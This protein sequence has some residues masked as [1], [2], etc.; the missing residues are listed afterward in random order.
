MP[1]QKSPS[2]SKRITPDKLPALYQGFSESAAKAQRGYLRAQSSLLWMLVATAIV[3]AVGKLAPPLLEASWAARIDRATAVAA[4]TLFSLGLVLTQ[5]HR[6]RGAPESWYD[7]RALAES[8]KS[9]AWKFLMRAEPYVDADSEKVF[10]SDLLKIMTDARQKAKPTG[11]TADQ[12]TSEMRAVRALPIAERVAI[13]RNDRILDQSVWYTK[14][15]SE[16]QMSSDRWQLFVTTALTIGVALN[17]ISIISKPFGAVG[18]LASAVV[19]CAIAWS[20][21]RRFRELAHSYAFTAHEIGLISAETD[22]VNDVEVARFVAD[23]ESV[24][25]REHTMWRARRESTDN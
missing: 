17:V 5:R 24:F 6:Q 4:V 25:S 18:S 10:R 16:L 14:K 3:S 23:C 1:P 7:A 20:Q 12:I 22:P 15:S 19:P 21:T 2:P 13:Y 11:I 9:M 8:A